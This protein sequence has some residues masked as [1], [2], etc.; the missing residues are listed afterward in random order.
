M[1]F[2]CHS[3]TA[4]RE[5]DHDVLFKGERDIATVV[6][7]GWRIEPWRPTPEWSN[8]GRYTLTSPS[9]ENCGTNETREGAAAY[10]LR[11]MQTS[12]WWA[13]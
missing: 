2:W 5:R 1:G 8:P 10:A 12:A 7:A 3:F 13:K 9:G 4:R 11:L 6:L